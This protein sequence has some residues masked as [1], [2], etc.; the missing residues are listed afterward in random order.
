MRRGRPRKNLPKQDSGTPE[1]QLKHANGLTREPLDA[2]LQDKLISASSHQAGL[3]LRWLYSLAHGIPT[4]SSAFFHLWES[5]SNR[6]D[7]HRWR[8]KREQE[9]AALANRLQQRGQLRLLLSY[10]IHGE[11]PK[12][13]PRT[14]TQAFESLEIEIEKL[15]RPNALQECDPAPRP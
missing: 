9:Y 5:N 15:L 11:T 1:L 3:H 13:E 10:C 7:N 14:I 8:E 4:P 2:L 6:H 12:N